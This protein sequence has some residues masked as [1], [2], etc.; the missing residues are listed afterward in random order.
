MRKLGLASWLFLAV[1]VSGKVSD[2]VPPAKEKVFP[3]AE[4]RHGYQPV[5]NF[6]LAF[7]QF[8]SKSHREVE[9]PV[10]QA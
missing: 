8:F 2:A 1:L 7:V 3:E 10:K 6:E 9:M 4:G 5:P